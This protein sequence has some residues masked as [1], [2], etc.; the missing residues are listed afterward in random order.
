MKIF[1]FKEE[2]YYDNYALKDFNGIVF[3]VLISQKNGVLDFLKI[4]SVVMYFVFDKVVVGHNKVD[5]E[6]I[7]QWI[8]ANQYQ[9]KKE[10]KKLEII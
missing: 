6:A 2:I 5:E 10:H 3:E 1:I 9:M 7:K 4:E 8:I